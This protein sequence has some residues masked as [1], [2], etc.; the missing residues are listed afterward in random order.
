MKTLHSHITAF[1]VIV[2]LTSCL[3]SS[4]AQSIN[5]NNILTSLKKLEST[6]EGHLGIFA[7][8]TANG[9]TVAYRAGDI[10]PTGC[11]SK[12]IGVSALLNK[13]LSTPSLLMEKITYSAQDLED[14]SPVTRK[15]LA[16]GMTV[17]ALCAAAISFSDNT[18]MNLLLKQIG[19]TKGMAGFAHS[20]GNASFRQDNGWPDEAFSGG[21]NNLEDSSTPK[22]M[23]DSLQK[24][25]LG[26]ALGKDQQTLLTHW[27]I[28]T[29]TGAKRIRSGIPKDW[30]IG[31]K[32]GTGALYG[33]TNDI[34]IVWP[35]HHKPI[36]IGIFYTS[37]HKQAKKREDV[38]SKASAL[39]VKAFSDNDPELTH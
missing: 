33:T 6:T 3:N 10:F 7:V 1:F 29:H 9:H 39:L 11:T 25:T 27:L 22:D 35:P 31:N 8:N 4:F 36:F 16:D 2:V 17:Q 19:G 14:W 5:S 18:A 32:T 12:V 30:I 28:N 21:K 37:E 26:N 15:N 20:I 23:T 13:S 38:I 34:A 24:L